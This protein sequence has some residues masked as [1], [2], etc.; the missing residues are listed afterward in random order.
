VNDVALQLAEDEVQ[1]V[2]EMHTNIGGNAEGFTRIAFPTF[3]IPL[4]T[5][6][7]V[8]KFDI[9]LMLAGLTGDLIFEVKNGLVVAQL[10]DVVETLAGFPFD[11]GQFIEVFRGGYQRLFAD[12][13]AAQA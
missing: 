5:R 2:V 11:Q 10:K 7:D 12:D 3:H 6:G 13:I 4:A 8:G 1:H 9:V